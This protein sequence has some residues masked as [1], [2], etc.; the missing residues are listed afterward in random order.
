MHVSVV[1]VT[2]IVIV[3]RSVHFSFGSCSRG[4]GPV[5]F[6]AR[7]EPSVDVVS[8]GIQFRFQRTKS[9]L[10]FGI[11]RVEQTDF[12]FVGTFFL[13]QRLRKIGLVGRSSSKR[14]YLYVFDG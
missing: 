12:P 11:A 10:Q 9:L 2:G 13:R 14:R 5:E 4:H 6:G 3:E 8:L 7:V 1:V